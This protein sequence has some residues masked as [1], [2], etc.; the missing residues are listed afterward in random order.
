EATMILALSTIFSLR[1][2]FGAGEPPRFS[3]LVRDQI[4]VGASDV[5]DALRV[6]GGTDLLHEPLG[7]ERRGEAQVV[8]QLEAACR[9]VV[10]DVRSAEVLAAIGGDEP[11]A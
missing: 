3:L 4:G 1:F 8:E 7:I 6:F 11:R 5:D 2:G 10:R 9:R